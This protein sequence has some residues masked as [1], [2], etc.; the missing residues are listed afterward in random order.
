MTYNNDIISWL[1]DGARYYVVMKL[2]MSLSQDYYIVNNEI[3]E[4]LAVLC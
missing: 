4:I 3:R 1:Y 2:I